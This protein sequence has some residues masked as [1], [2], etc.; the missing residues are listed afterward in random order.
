MVP[1]KTW[2]SENF[3]RILKL[4]LMSLEVSFLHGVIFT[5]LESQLFTKESRARIFNWD[6]GVSASLGFYH[7]SPLPL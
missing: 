4:F 7:S 1:R 3:G 6:L 2:V 5:F